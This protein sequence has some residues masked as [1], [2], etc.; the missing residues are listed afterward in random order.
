MARTSTNFACPLVLVL[1]QVSFMHLVLL[2]VFSERSVFRHPLDLLHFSLSQLFLGVC[3]QFARRVHLWLGH[4]D[5]RP[6]RDGGLLS[7]WTHKR[8]TQ[9]ITYF[10]ELSEDNDCEATSLW[11]KRW[12]HQRRGLLLL[13]FYTSWPQWSSS[14]QTACIPPVCR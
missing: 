13:P 4:L 11:V 10:I 14:I 5:V 6:Q 7:S 3:W 8:A 1:S 12:T 9:T 2:A